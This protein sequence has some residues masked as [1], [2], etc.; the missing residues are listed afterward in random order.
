M[1]IRITYLNQD[2]ATELH[3]VEAIT[4]TSGGHLIK[5][6]GNDAVLHRRVVGIEIVEVY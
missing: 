5:C 3:A 4:L 1:T 6:F 2:G